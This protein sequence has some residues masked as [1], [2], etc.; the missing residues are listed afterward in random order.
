MAAKIDWSMLPKA[1][2]RLAISRT[3]QTGTDMVDRG[4]LNVLPARKIAATEG[5]GCMAVFG[6]NAVSYV[7]ILYQF[8]CGTLK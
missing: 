2:Q 6:G 8:A 5:V 3:R 1:D 7:P 4:R